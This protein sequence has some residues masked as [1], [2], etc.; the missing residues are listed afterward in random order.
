M[1]TRRF[2]DNVPLPELK[3]AAGGG[4]AKRG[5]L[6]RRH[7]AGRRHYC[8]KIHRAYKTVVDS[9]ENTFSAENTFLPLFKFI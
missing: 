8:L 2:R 7:G 4:R 6:S 1:L 5:F 3:A 9:N